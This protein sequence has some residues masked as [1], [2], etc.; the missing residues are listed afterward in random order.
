MPPRARCYTDDVF[1]DQD[2]VVKINIES[3]RRLHGYL[4]LPV[5]KPKWSDC[6]RPRD[7][8]FC[9]NVTTTAQKTCFLGPVAFTEVLHTR[10]ILG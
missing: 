3:E 7:G 5:A 8:M 1:E 4:L 2:L 9:P 6:R 10:C